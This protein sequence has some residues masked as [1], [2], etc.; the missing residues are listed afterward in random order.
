VNIRTYI[1]S[2]IQ[3]YCLLQNASYCKNQ[4]TF[5]RHYGGRGDIETDIEKTVLKAFS[6]ILNNTPLDDFINGHKEFLM[7]VSET[8][9]NDLPF[10]TKVF[11]VNHRIDFIEKINA[12]IRNKLKETLRDK[13]GLSEDEIDYILAFSV[14]GRIAIYR[15]WILSGFKQSEDTIPEIPEKISSNGFD[16]FLQ[17]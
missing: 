16:S 17:Q 9:K 14:A 10:Y 3:Y 6:D 11:Q 12:T 4:S 2:D 13:T 5:Y 8:I 15:K 7:K 1:I